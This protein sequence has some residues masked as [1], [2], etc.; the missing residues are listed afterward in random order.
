MVGGHANVLEQE[1]TVQEE[2]V[3]L[4]STERQKA[5][6]SHVWCRD[7]VHIMMLAFEADSCKALLCV[8]AFTDA[9]AAVKLVITAACAPSEGGQ[10]G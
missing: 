10:E 8:P 5:Q 2:H 4:R 7:M 3:A 6:I 9:F 1:G